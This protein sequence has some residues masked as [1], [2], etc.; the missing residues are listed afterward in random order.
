[1]DDLETKGWTLTQIINLQL[2]TNKYVQLRGA[3]YIHLPKEIKN[4]TAV[5]NIKNEDEESRY[6]NNPSPQLIRKIDALLYI[7]MR[8]FNAYFKENDLDIFPLRIT[9]K[10]LDKLVNLFYVKGE[11]SH[12]CLIKN[13]SR[14]IGSQ[15]TSFGHKIYL[16]DRCLMHFYSEG[17]LKSHEN[18]C[19][20]NK[21][22]K[23][24][25]PFGGN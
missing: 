12:Y 23:I 25:M 20:T 10:K 7:V 3:S 11:K 2:R 24:E 16:H 17:K 21:P 9:E 8:T 13:L 5:L 4:K 22:V 19:K 6:T 18:Y 15:L 1:M 14:L